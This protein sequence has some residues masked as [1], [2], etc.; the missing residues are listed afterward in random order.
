MIGFSPETI[1]ST[2]LNSRRHN[3]CWTKT[4]PITVKKKDIFLQSSPIN[5]GLFVSLVISY[6]MF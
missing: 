1:Y 6:Y 2:A 3:I 4:F 5:S